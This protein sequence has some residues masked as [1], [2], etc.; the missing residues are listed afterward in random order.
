MVVWCRF[1]G[2]LYPL[3]D[4][5]HGFFGIVE[6]ELGV[7]LLPELLSLF[8]EL[9][10]LDGDTAEGQHGQLVEEEGLGP[11]FPLFVEH[12]DFITGKREGEHF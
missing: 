4:V 3:D 2:R 1:A 6:D 7:E 12:A 9:V 11:E 10:F 5:A 8:L